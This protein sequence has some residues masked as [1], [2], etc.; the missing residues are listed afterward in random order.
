[1]SPVVAP[2]VA[3]LVL[4]N[5]APSPAPTPFTLC[6][7]DEAW[8]ILLYAGGDPDRTRFDNNEPDW[9]TTFQ[10]LAGIE[11]CGVE[12]EY[13]VAFE[14]TGESNIGTSYIGF[15]DQTRPLLGLRVQTY[16]QLRSNGFGV[17]IYIRNYEYE[18]EIGC[19]DGTWCSFG[20]DKP[21]NQ[22]RV[23]GYQL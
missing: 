23:V 21:I 1:V 19:P 4:S 11:F 14:G 9:T 17:G 3:P 18:E 7:A 20:P 10:E 12:F 8:T 22:I 15:T 2:V 13:S 5:E 6:Q 16:G